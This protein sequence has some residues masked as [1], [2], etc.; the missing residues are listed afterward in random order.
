[1]LAGNRR[2]SAP[3]GTIVAAGQV[4]VMR[5]HTA[6]SPI[7]CCLLA[8][9][10][11]APPVANGAEPGDANALPAP[12]GAHADFFGI[13]GR[14]PWYEWNTDPV[15]FPDDVNRDALEGMARDLALAG[16]G[17]VR[18]ELH[19]ER[20]P[21]GLSPD[22]D[23]PGGPGYID[24]RKWD[25]F[26]K[27]CAPRYGLKVLLLLGQ[28]LLARAPETDPDWNY[29]RIND[30]PDR[31]DGTNLYIR[32][33]AA[34]ARAVADHFGP[35][36]AAYELLNEANISATL[37]R[38]TDGRQ[39]ETDPERFGAL[40]AEVYGGIKPAHPRVQLIAGGLLYGPG[41]GTA[42]ADT[43]Y[44]GRLYRAERVRQ[45]HAATGH[46]PFDGVATHPYHVGTPRQI[47]EHL[48]RLHG[49]VAAAGDGGKLWLTEIGIGG[50]PA[51]VAPGLL[52]ARPTP[53]ELA[54]ATFIR[55]LF[56]LLLAEARP[57]LARVFWFKYEDYPFGVSSVEDEDDPYLPTTDWSEHGLVRL[58][59][60]ARQ[61]YLHPP[62]PRK[63]AF[64]AFQEIANP[65][66]LP[67]A[68]ESP[69]DQPPDARFFPETRHA[70]AGAF[71]RYW[72]QHGGLARFGFPLTAVFELGGRRVQY[73]E[74]A[75][76]EHHPENPAPHDVQLGLLTSYLTAGRVFDSAPARPSGRYFP[77]TGHT[78]D[79]VFLAYWQARG[80][81]AAYG[82]PISEELREVNQAD[83]RE[84]T[85]QYFERARFEHHPER[86]GTPFEV[87]LGLVGVETLNSGGWYR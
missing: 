52:A 49:V 72:D 65:G 10:L 60:T 67:T 83:G 5:R 40:L 82:Y 46:Y 27:E 18:I 63:P 11:L 55:E 17:W 8:L 68:P 86:A 6:R 34:R 7:I 56:P 37:F 76:F 13:V 38:F 70:V 2:E 22:P 14:D 57:F 48:R 15:R 41:D 59:V 29:A 30:P 12:R 24:W 21:A 54:Q 3:Q 23:R 26:V 36:V 28:T 74:R 79:G 80:G 47:V 84:Y 53:S 39:Q 31:P 45:Y 81:L 50:T 1:M 69:W 85:V 58:R 33:Y 66:A 35:S 77:E 9:L 78:L 32:R 64:A 62:A 61:A 25:W 73:F 43:T 16:A 19:A 42:S 87:L 71:L 4:Q 20:D 75:R 44:L 51:T